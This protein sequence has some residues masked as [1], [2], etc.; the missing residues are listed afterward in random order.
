MTDN[1]THCPREET[2]FAA[3]AQTGTAGKTAHS[4][5]SNACLIR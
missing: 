2:A 5:L 4:L 3:P 1:G